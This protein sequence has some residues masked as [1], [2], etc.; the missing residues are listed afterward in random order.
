MTAQVIF[1]TATIRPKVGT[2]LLARMDPD[3]RRADY[4]VAFR[5][6]AKVVARQPDY[7]LVLIRNSGADLS[8]FVVMGEASG[9]KDRMECWSDEANEDVSLNR[10]FLETAL[11]RTALERSPTLRNAEGNIWKISGRYSIPNIERILAYAPESFDIYLNLRDYPK[12]ALDFYIAGFSRA[13]LE[14]VVNRISNRLAVV[15]TGELILREAI[16]QGEFKDLKVVPRFT[17]VPRIIGHRGH[18]NAAYHGI[19]NTTKFWV[20]RV[21]NTVVPGLW[22]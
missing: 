10:L 4:I 3:Q 17:I 16:E 22:I 1:L 13:G 14:A 18:D 8:N 2:H 9:I 15:D 7:R 21:A 6:Y 11:I 20:R 19:G 5:E 12:R